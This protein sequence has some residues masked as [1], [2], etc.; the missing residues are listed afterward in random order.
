MMDIVCP[1]KLSLNLAVALLRLVF[2]LPIFPLWFSESA[3]AE[4]LRV[5][6]LSVPPFSVAPSL[7]ATPV[8]VKTNDVR[9]SIP[10][11]FLETANLVKNKDDAGRYSTSAAL[12]IV[13]VYPEFIGAT[14]ATVRC[15]KPLSIRTCSNVIVVHLLPSNEDWKLRNGPAIDEAAAA[16]RDDR[17]GLTKVKTR[18]AVGPQDVYVYYGGS[19]E[20]SVVI[21]CLQT[22]V[23]TLYGCA[24]RL[25]SFGVPVLYHYEQ[26]LLSH[27]RQIH[28][29]VTRLLASFH[30]GG[31]R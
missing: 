19:Y 28:D 16:L 13:L 27:W 26:G 23:P 30:I 8:Q 22:E 24:V 4:S 12:R 5:D 20:K 14:S 10:R 1:S 6:T 7:D 17:F 11:N 29:E 3:V 18:T 9:W 25:E 2:F 21:D 31:A 15:F